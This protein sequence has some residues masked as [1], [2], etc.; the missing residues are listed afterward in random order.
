MR[1][2]RIWFN[3]PG[4]RWGRALTLAGLGTAAIAL[5][6]AAERGLWDAPELA[7]QFDAAPAAAP[8]SV[9]AARR[10]D[11][12]AQ[13]TSARA[14]DDSAPSP[15]AAGEVR[16]CGLGS[17]AVGPDGPDLAARR[18]R[19]ERSKPV[20][21]RWL[22]ALQAAPEPRSKA[23][24]LVLAPLLAAPP[25]APVRPACADEADCPTP[26]P[27]AATSAWVSQRERLAE[28]AAQAG[29][30]AG[31]LGLAMQACSTGAPAPETSAC[32][33]LAVEDWIAVDPTHAEPWLQLADRA[34][35]AGDAEATAE[36][37]RRALAQPFGRLA[38]QALFGAVQA[39]QPADAGVLERLQMGDVLAMLRAAWREPGLAS[40]ASWCGA[41][42]LAEVGRRELCQQLAEQLVLRGTTLQQVAGGRALGRSLGWFPERMAAAGRDLDA[43]QRL[44][45]SFSG[46]QAYDCPALQRQLDYQAAVAAQ[47]E[48]AAVRRFAATLRRP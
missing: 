26:A 28:I 15:G 4:V 10:V 31:V 18:L 21:A 29:R 6:V 20:M 32:A 39:A 46:E 5:W 27:A 38:E 24:A 7:V 3:R 30:D 8:A 25:L 45:A 17:I 13:A 23:A 36:A 37:L 11:A 41:P 43:A 12:G 40:A 33:R 47:G 2:T 14:A 1:P 44:F 22:E 34:Q 19:A 42:A 16:V 48:V 35:A 9:A